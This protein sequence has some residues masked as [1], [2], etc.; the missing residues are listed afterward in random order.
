[1]VIQVHPH[2]LDPFYRKATEGYEACISNPDN[3]YLQAEAPVPV[4]EIVVQ[5]GEVKV[6]F[7][8]ATVG[9]YQLEVQLWLYVQE[10]HFGR[11]VSLMDATGE[12]LAD[13]LVFY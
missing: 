4:S 11:Y 5:Q 3:A 6:V 1:M 2:D 9:T 13:S 7:S 10:K 12:V 8:P